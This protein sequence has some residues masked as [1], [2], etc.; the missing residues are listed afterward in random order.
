M[1]KIEAYEILSE[2]LND[3]RN[4]GEMFLEKNL[5]TSLDFEERGA[6]GK[7]YS[8]QIS[9]EQDSSQ[10]KILG[11]IHD[12]NTHSFSILEEEMSLDKTG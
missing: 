1:D 11:K 3:I 10:Y 9:V 12:N 6:S 8:I 5:G 4:Q 2:R 7:L